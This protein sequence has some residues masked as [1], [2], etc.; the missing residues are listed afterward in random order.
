MKKILFIAGCQKRGNSTGLIGMTLSAFANFDRTEYELSLYDTSYFEEHNPADYPVNNYYCMPKSSLDKI[1]KCI[2]WFRGKYADCLQ[3]RTLK[4][5][6][7]SYSF[8]LVVIYQIPVWADLCVELCNKKNITVMMWPWGS[9]ILRCSGRAKE[10]I[11]RAFR[12]VDLVGGAPKSNCILSAQNDY[13]V[14]ESKLR[15]SKIRMAGVKMLQD[16][17]GTKSRREMHQEIGIPYSDFNI[18][19]SYNGDEAHRHRNI[20]ESIVANKDVLPQNY[21]LIFPMTYGASPEYLDSIRHLCEE[22]QLHAVFLTEFLSD[23]QMAY[24]HLVTDLFIA[25]LVSDCGNGFMIESLFAKNRIV[26][27][28]WLHY[29]QFEQ[30][31]IPYH[32]IDTPEDLPQMLREIFTDKVSSPEI[33]EKLVEMYRVPEDYDRG[34]YR[35]AIIDEYSNR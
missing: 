21:Q 11:K 5:I 30:F 14:P 33:P 20:V 26:T 34:A 29:E 9:D 16:L 19:C 23:E 18:V 17:S 6:L 32:L 15:L 22:N 13:G 3:R 8:D 12:N 24:L 1:I 10:H 31:G 27:G 35:K 7:R 28:K 4:K 2:P 25:I